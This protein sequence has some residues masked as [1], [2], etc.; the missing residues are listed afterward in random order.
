[1]NGPPYPPPPAVPPP[2]PQYEAGSVPAGLPK[3]GNW[4]VLIEEQMSTNRRTTVRVVAWAADRAGACAVAAHYA[5]TY[6]PRH[7]RRP[8]SRN[9]FRYDEGHWT[10]LIDGAMEAFHFSVRVAEHKATSP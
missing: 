4:A 9:A 2:P 7:P 8:Q 3:P 10:V 6:E 5:H 1:M